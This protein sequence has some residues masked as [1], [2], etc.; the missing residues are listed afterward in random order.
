M[1]V[2][3]VT[4]KREYDEIFC[5]IDALQTKKPRLTPS[6]VQLY[7]AQSNSQRDS[8]TTYLHSPAQSTGGRSLLAHVPR[9]PLAALQD[10]VVTRTSAGSPTAELLVQ[11]LRS[12]MSGRP[13]TRSSGNK[14]NQKENKMAPGKSDKKTDKKDNVINNSS[15]LGGD[16]HKEIRKKDDTN[17][18]DPSIMVDSDQQRPPKDPVPPTSRTV[19]GAPLV[20]KILQW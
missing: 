4:L 18:E 11:T 5:E 10:K 2:Q 7:A 19:E 17:E 14:D 12:T 9:P 16:P 15:N 1:D 13:D 20:V 8:I 6:P 3:T